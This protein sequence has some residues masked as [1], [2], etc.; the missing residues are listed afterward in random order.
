MSQNVDIKLDHWKRNLLDLGQRNRLINC[1]LPRE[2]GQRAAR[3]TLL[4]KAPSLSELWQILVEANSQ[5]I[6]P[7]PLIENNAEDEFKETKI[8]LSD[9]AVLTNQ[10]ETDMY[11]TLHALRNRSRE[12]N[13]EKGINVLH[14]AFGF[15]NWENNGANGLEVR[16][17]LLLLA[18]QLSQEDVSA[19]FVLSRTDEEIVTNRFLEEK[20]RG[21]F[22]I[23]LPSFNEEMTLEEYL[24]S[25]RE[26]IGLEWTISDDV[27]QL[28]LFSVVEI[29]MYHDLERNAD[30]IRNHPVIKVISGE[31]I[32]DDSVNMS[33]MSIG[34]YNHDL[35]EPAEEFCVVD[36]DSS[37]QDAIRS[38]KAGK[39]FILQGAPGTGKS[40]TITNIIAELI[41]TGKKVLFV[42]EKMA[43]LE[44]V[45]SRLKSVG[46]HP[47]CLILH[48]HVVKRRD[49][50]NQ[51]NETINLARNQVTVRQEAF[52]SLRKLKEVR[53]SLN[54]YSEELHTS[55]APLGLTIH[56]IQGNIAKYAKYPDIDYIQNDAD[57]FTSE[58]LGRCRDALE[59]LV[60]IV[61][62][63][64]HQ[65]DNP[66]QGYAANQHI[67]QEFVQR[68]AV[69]ADSLFSLVNE[70]YTLFTQASNI[71]YTVNDWSY[72][73]VEDIEE[74]YR[75]SL[76]SHH[77]PISLLSLELDEILWMLDNCIQIQELTHKKESLKSILNETKQ[78]LDGTKNEYNILISKQ[79]QTI[80]ELLSEVIDERYDSKLLSSLTALIDMA[81]N[82]LKESFDIAN[83]K[84]EATVAK[85]KFDDSKLQQEISDLEEDYDETVLSINALELRSLYR[86]EYRSKLK[87]ASSGFKQS[88][89]KLIAHRKTAE[90]LSYETALIDLEKILSI[91]RMLE[92]SQHVEIAKVEFE[93]HKNAYYDYQQKAFDLQK[94]ILKAQNQELL[95][96]EV[97]ED[98]QKVFDEYEQNERQLLEFDFDFDM[99]LLELNKKLKTMFDKNTEFNSL[100]VKI[101]WA[102]EFQR[103][104]SKFQL[105]EKYISLICATKHEIC[106]RLKDN[107]HALREWKN[108]IN[109]DFEKYTNLF[110][111]SHKTKLYNLPLR[112]FNELLAKRKETIFNLEYLIDY[113][114][115]ERRIAELGIADYLAKAKE[116]NMRA[117]EIIPVFEKCFYRSLLDSTL[118]KF[119]VIREFRRHRQDERIELFKTLD[120]SHLNISKEMLQAKL[121]ERLPNTLY[122]D[123]ETALLRREMSKQRNLLPTR[124]LIANLPNIL[125][126]VKPCMMM[127]P[128]AVSTLLGSSDY[129]FDT[130]IFDEASQMS[131]ET[132]IGAIFRAKQVI[133]AGDSKQLPP[134][135]F[136]SSLSGEY[137][138]NEDESRDDSKAYESLLDEAGLLPTLTLRWHYRSRHEYLMAFSNMEIYGNKLITFP[139]P[140]EKNEGIGVEYVHVPNGVYDRVGRNGNLIEAKK[141]ADM[142]FEHF[143]KYGDKKSLGV[144]AFDEVQQMAIQDA[145][146]QKRLIMP[147]YERFFKEDLEEYFFTKRLETVQGDERDTIICSIGFAPDNAGKFLMDFGLLSRAGGDRGLNVAITRARYHLQLVGS[148]MPMDIAAERINAIGSKLLKQYI[149][150]ASNG[151]NVILAETTEDK[152]H[153]FDSPFEASVLEFLVSNGYSVRTQVGCSGYR[154]DMAVEYP[155]ECKYSGEFYV[156]GIECDGYMYHSTRTA[157]E[158]DRLRQ[159]ILESMGWTI[160]RIWSTD[161]IKDP[162]SEGKRLIEAVEKAVKKCEES[163][164][165]I[166]I[167]ATDVEESE[168]L[169]VAEQTV[170]ESVQVEAPVDLLKSE[171]YGEQID[172]IPLGDIVKM[173][174]HVLA[175]NDGLIKSELFKEIALYGYGWKRQ[176]A[177]IKAV[178]ERVYKKLLRDNI[179]EEI[180]GE[181]ILKEKA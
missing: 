127:S 5:L 152:H 65:I 66:W 147:M 85:Y 7:T 70:G 35:T 29:N 161:W 55:I 82:N 34:N 14:L 111:E 119:N 137:A 89:N 17:P 162:H 140:S 59:E 51:L 124:L 8:E 128:L 98:Y 112:S 117:D 48:G 50:L 120:K 38:A 157:R 115:A 15:L 91:Q 69:D 174:R 23:E 178:F 159:D 106:N 139:P 33:D 80:N 175:I 168:L 142:V 2:N 114:N 62:E 102:S 97:T 108:K 105:G 11:Q 53:R 1:P 141:V 179:I 57:Q 107:I 79:N 45:N 181:I 4:I 18:V 151:M 116:M 154:V 81:T 19:P 39:S 146:L 156:I 21:D 180:D 60:H 30:K 93:V 109:I 90:K 58:L 136:L 96:K 36:A 155:K 95:L 86:T 27:A 103:I 63:D 44:V 158:R 131:T 41:A 12:F 32:D 24:T 52:D 123:V 165:S 173:M 148:V 122:N 67:T 25:V 78:K 133:I 37:Q 42:S 87:R 40:Q 176:G 172:D 6:F 145:L 61:K 75:V 164:E 49:I 64:G 20:L 22:G 71:L 56:Q 143:K 76:N 126:V 88:Q 77:I 171:F 92:D 167:A 47:F 46:L 113:R 68:F 13:L 177:R 83:D 104:A 16:S 84:F 132:A 163:R 125:P 72:L 73:G 110:D 121:I 170:E 130:V 138:E 169:E 149:D 166:R 9:S 135:N 3:H 144:I 10:S 160:H 94:T 150:F 99:I 74:I 101:E 31:H 153:Y 26:V 134:M 118:P 43:A 129:E 28:S 100:K 54:Q